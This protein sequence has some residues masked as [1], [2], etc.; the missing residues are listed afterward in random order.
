MARVSK[1]AS[2]F[3]MKHL[4]LA[5]APTSQCNLRCSYC[6]VLDQLGRQ[7]MDIEK[8][9]SFLHQEINEKAPES[10]VVE[11]FGGEPTLNTPFVM[12]IVSE[13]KSAFLNGK[14]FFR[15]FTNGIT[16]SCAWDEMDEIIISLDGPYEANMD[17][18]RSKKVYDKIVNNI[19]YLLD[20]NYPVTLAF[21]VKPETPL[22]EVF[23]FFC[24]TFPTLKSF[25]FE[26]LTTTEWT[27]EALLEVFEFINENIFLH[28]DRLVSIPKEFLSSA[29]Y[30]GPSCADTVRALALDGTVH[31]CRDATLQN[32]NVFFR[33]AGKYTDASPC[34][35][36]AREWQELP[37]W[38]EKD[39]QEI[40]VRPFYEM[41]WDTF[42][43]YRN[44]EKMDIQKPLLYKEIIN[45]YKRIKTR[46]S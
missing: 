38:L 4:E 23:A 12:R 9:V 22:G 33:S 29:V 13:A 19:H 34:W 44:G 43:T 8:A 27:T 31:A 2:G 45:V 1:T 10:L 26:L 37:C 14:P 20:N 24:N 25:S 42:R 36:K 41:M 32:D 28:G 3:N 18:T 35:I 46:S 11:F 30:K 39:F 5:F 17:R 16:S 7:E 40:I 21:V 6:C 15:M